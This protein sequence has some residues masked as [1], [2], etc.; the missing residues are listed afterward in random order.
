M[1]CTSLTVSNGVVFHIKSS[2]KVISASKKMGSMLWAPEKVPLVPTKGQQPLGITGAYA[3]IS[4]FNAIFKTSYYEE[5][6]DGSLSLFP[7]STT[8]STDGEDYEEDHREEEE[9]LTLE[10][11]ME[12]DREDIEQ[13]ELD[14]E[15]VRMFHIVYQRVYLYRIV[16]SRFEC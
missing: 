4:T 7:C 12:V 3:A 14:R 6:G 5:N 8:S 1:F 15:Q 11:N 2:P 10:G 9:D 16:Q 13:E